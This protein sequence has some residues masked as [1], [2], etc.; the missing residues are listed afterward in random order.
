MVLRC[1]RDTHLCASIGLGSFCQ[2]SLL[3]S[4]RKRGPIITESAVIMG[5]GSPPASAGVGRDDKCSVLILVS[6]FQTAIRTTPFLC[7]ARWR[8]AVFLSFCP[9]P[10]EGRAERREGAFNDRA[11]EARLTTLT[12]RVSHR[13][14]T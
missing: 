11:C 12:R 9:A 14:Q 2:I 6:R 4:P 10:T 1:A 13:F 8:R 3:S 7:A 5:P